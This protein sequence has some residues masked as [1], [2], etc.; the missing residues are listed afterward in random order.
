MWTPLLVHSDY[1]LMNSAM[2][3]EKIAKACKELGYTHCGIMD[4]GSVS[5]LMEFSEACKEH[6]ITPI[7]GIEAFVCSLPSEEKEGNRTLY[8]MGIIATSLEG[9][10]ALFK[11]SSQAN[12][13]I[14]DKPRLSLEEWASYAKDWIVFS[15]YNGSTIYGN[16]QSILEKISL[17]KELFKDFYVAISINNLNNSLLRKCA[18]KMET[19]C[20]AVHSSHYASKEDASDHRVLLCSSLKTTLPK[21]N[22][23]LHKDEAKD[24]DV[25]QF[26]KKDNFHIPTKEEIEEWYKENPEEIKACEEIV[27]KCKPYN[28]YNNPILPT[29]DKNIDAYEE[30]VKLAREGWKNLFS[31]KNGTKEYEEYGERIKMELSVIKENNL[32]NYFLIVA[33]ICRWARENGILTG[34]GRGSAAGCLISYLLGITH[35]DPIKYGLLFSRFYNSSRKN[36]LPDIDLDFP[37]D[38]RELVINYVI[39]KYGYGSVAKIATFGRLQGK[40]I[41]KEVLRV[42]EACDFQTVNAITKF[43]PDESKISDDLEEM[44]KDDEENAKIL[45]WAVINNAKDLAPWVRLENDG[46]YSGELGKYFAQAVRLEGLYKSVGEHAS[47]VVVTPGNVDELCPLIIS[48][49]G[50]MLAGMPYLLLEKMG[51]TKIDILGVSVYQKLSMFINCLEYGDIYV[52]NSIKQEDPA[53]IDDDISNDVESC[54]TEESLCISR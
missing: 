50:K 26:F 34:I 18:Q 43:I 10:K 7:F 3:C 11:A 20:V 30:I 54:H 46:S 36:T 28:L 5:G 44:R 39:Q 45:Y 15:G 16:E 40:S 12:R 38:K 2:D 17:H 4:N 33:D 24:I 21:I 32:S 48:K 31:W 14:Y 52:G 25:E 22:G 13:N 8:R 49:K 47:G 23:S 9:C 41:I 19:K 27:N 35:A 42:H 37:P 1:S 53:D 29:F 6:K 51:I